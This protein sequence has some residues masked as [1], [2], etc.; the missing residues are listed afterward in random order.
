MANRGLYV[1]EENPTRTRKEREG[2]ADELTEDRRDGDKEKPQ[3]QR[4]L[5]IYGRGKPKGFPFSFLGCRVSR[6]KRF[7]FIYI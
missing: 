3:K 1:V 4:Q 6:L 5:Q 2:A 7:A